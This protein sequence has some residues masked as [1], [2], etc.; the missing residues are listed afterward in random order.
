LE[1]ILAY[2]LE[3]YDNLEKNLIELIAKY[4]R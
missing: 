2:L 4:Y 3:K 1:S